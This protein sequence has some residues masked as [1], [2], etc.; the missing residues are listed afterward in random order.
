VACFKENEDLMRPPRYLEHLGR[1]LP[2]A[3]AALLDGPQRFQVLYVEDL[4]A[5]CDYLSTVATSPWRE[6]LR[7][8]YGV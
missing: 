5:H 1:D 3:W 2:T 4:L 7:E 6:Y 8:R